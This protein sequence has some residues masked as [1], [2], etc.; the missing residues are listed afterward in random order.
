MCGNTPRARAV[1]GLVA[2]VLLIGPL[3]AGHVAAEQPPLQ[4]AAIAEQIGAPL[5]STLMFTDSSGVHRALGAF[6][7]GRMPVVLQLAYF[8]CPMLCPIVFDGLAEALAQSSVA[9]GRDVRV[10]TVSIDPQDQ[11]AVAAS[12]RAKV[13]KRLNGTEPFEWQ[14]LV[15]RQPEIEQLAKAVG[16]Q[17]AR[18]PASGEYAH[19]AA[20]VV[21]T[22]TG[23][24]SQYLYGAT[25]EPAAVAAAIHV[26]AGTPI[27]DH[28]PVERFLLRCFHYVPA[29][30]R[31][32]GTVTWVLRGGAALVTL[33]LGCALGLLWRRERQ[34]A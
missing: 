8:S 3:R 20:I 1:A 5:P 10:L 31:H 26:A 19:A 33:I 14:I 25:F 34:R 22:P 27:D 7:D 11:P 16:F 24:V 6:V 28:R 21:L 15:G 12:W 29:L 9:V 17:Y 30:R 13:R 32:G 4:Q 2:T 23:R 18:D